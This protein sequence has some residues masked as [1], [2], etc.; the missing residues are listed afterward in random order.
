VLLLL[1]LLLLLQLLLPSPPPPLLFC[2]GLSHPMLCNQSAP[3]LFINQRHS[4]G[5]K[6]YLLLNHFLL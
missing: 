2:R 6:L 1:L 4:I 5:S 3:S